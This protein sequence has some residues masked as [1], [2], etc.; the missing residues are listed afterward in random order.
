M[1]E[2]DRK[3]TEYFQGL[4]PEE[5]K[6]VTDYG[7]LDIAKDVGKKWWNWRKEQP[8]YGEMSDEEKL[9]FV[10][11]ASAGILKPMA[12][13]KTLKEA[14]RWETELASGKIVPY[15]KHLIGT[16]RRIMQTPQKEMRRL[17]D[18]T[19]TGDWSASYNLTRKL[20]EFDPA[21]MKRSSSWWHELAHARTD[22]PPPE[23]KEAFASFLRELVDDRLRGSLPTH[24]PGRIHKV[25]P[26]ELHAERV[27][28]LMEYPGRRNFS[29]LFNRAAKDPDLYNQV[30]KMLSPKTWERLRWEATTAAENYVELFGTRK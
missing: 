13:A 21:K 4:S 22:V 10:S 24:G 23:P 30:Q 25:L 5:R 29:K 19:F 2:I 12:V 11:G 20:I 27:L 1:V 3:F 8:S 28:Q 6:G 9:E 17:R 15:A 14:S 26:S 16:A 18:I 7:M